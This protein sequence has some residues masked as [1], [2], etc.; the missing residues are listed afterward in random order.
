MSEGNIVVMPPEPVARPTE[1]KLVIGLI[2]AVNRFA[3]DIVWPVIRPGVQEVAQLCEGE[4]DPYRVWKEV[5]GGTM[6]LYMGY[7]DRTGQ[8]K[9][10]NFQ[11]MFTQRLRNPFEDYAGFMAVQFLD[12]SAHVFAA[13]IMPA[14]RNSNIWQV[15]YDYI[16]AEVRKIGCPYLSVSMPH[17]TVES[18][19]RRGFVEVMTN[20]RKKL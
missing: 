11:E 1:A 13:Y 17:S 15:G 20:M 5:F 10:E 19:K 16:E 12:T 3:L 2:P 8:A 6:H 14:F 7:L 9:P 18:M 4:W